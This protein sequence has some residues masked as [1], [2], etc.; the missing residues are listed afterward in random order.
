M[1]SVACTFST[2]TVRVPPKRVF[3]LLLGL[4]VCAK[5]LN[6]PSPLFMGDVADL[7]MTICDTTYTH[8]PEPFQ[9]AIT[10]PWA[11]D[12]E[13]QMGSTSVIEFHVPT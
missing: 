4:K 8:L 9:S 11:T 7:P 10:Y 5:N 13:M 12:V 1:G 3:P 2:C 6:I